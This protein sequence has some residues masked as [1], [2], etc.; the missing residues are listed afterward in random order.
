MEGMLHFKTGMSYL[1][2]GIVLV[3]DT[4]QPI[5]S[6]NASRKR[7]LFRVTKPMRL[8]QFGLMTLLL[9]QQVSQR[10]KQRLKLY[11]IG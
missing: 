10:L 6:S 2:N 5:Q 4:S 11:A 7:L 1:E 8:T 9:H 3:L